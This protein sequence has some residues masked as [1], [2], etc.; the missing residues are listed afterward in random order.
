MLRIWLAFLINFTNQQHFEKFVH[1]GLSLAI[2]LNLSLDI[3]GLSQHC[4]ATFSVFHYGKNILHSKKQCVVS[5]RYIYQMYIITVKQAG[6]E[7]QYAQGH[8]KIPIISAYAKI[9]YVN[10]S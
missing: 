7:F 10:C 6:L 2:Y 9:L 1:I 5:S 3:H 8:F 4:F